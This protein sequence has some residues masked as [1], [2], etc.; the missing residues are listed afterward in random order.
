M[1]HRRNIYKKKKLEYL[2][3]F[4]FFFYL[5]GFDEYS[6][7]EKCFHLLDD[8]HYDMFHTTRKNFH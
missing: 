7:H 8:A 6:G 1:N 4:N 5:H 2:D 3:I